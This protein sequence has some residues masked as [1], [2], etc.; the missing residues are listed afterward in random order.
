M[1]NKKVIISFAEYENLQYEIKSLK[2]EVESLKTENR[3]LRCPAGSSLYII[4]R[5]DDKVEYRVLPPEQDRTELECSL[6]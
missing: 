1:D 6:V 3:N 5:T 4:Y 2:E